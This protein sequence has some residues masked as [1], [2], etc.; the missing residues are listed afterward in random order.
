MDSGRQVS[1]WSAARSGRL[2]LCCLIV[3]LG[4]LA[5]GCTGRGQA[6]P[7]RPILLICPWA[8]GGGTDRVARQLAVG[9]ER[10]LGVPVN[11]VNATGAS[12]VTGHTRG[13]LA[14]PDGYTITMMTVELNMLH[15]R[16][17]TPITHADFRPGALVNLDPAALF[18]RTDAPWQTLDELNEHIRQNPRTLRASG[19]ALGGIWHI[20]LAGWLT[21]IGLPTDAVRWISIEGASPSLQEMMAGG[22]EI[23]SA[24][25]PEARSLLEAGEIRAL[26]VM[27]DERLAQFPD[28]PTLKEQ[29]VDARFAAWRGIGVPAEA[30]DAVHEKLASSLA[31]VTNGQEF[32]QFMTNAGFNWAFEGPEE[33]GATL[34]RLDTTY[35][36]LLTS[37]AFR[38][39]GSEIVGPMAFPA[40]LGSLGLVVLV[41]L[42]ATGGLG[43]TASSDTFSWRGAGRVAVIL[44]AIL[45]YILVAETLGFV[46]TGFGIVAFLMWRLSVRWPVALTV[47]FVLILVVYQIF[48]IYLRVPLP[49][50]VFGW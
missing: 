47:S 2:W 16:G 50:G 49:R 34:R 33:F 37:D 5:G 30:P 24:S 40:I 13:A 6:Y 8:A 38:N 29:G 32:R 23:V 19:T 25:L 48:A 12:G 43:E 27:S 22:L 44:A 7:N 9:L 35:G 10:E 1:G 14:R 4:W 21:E 20:A 36:Q 39:M 46:L 15:W 31:N 18:V 17:L 26:G 28:V 45:V 41:I 3:L 11:V 42:L